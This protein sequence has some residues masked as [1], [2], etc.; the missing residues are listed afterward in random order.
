MIT[1]IS[2]KADTTNIYKNIDG[3]TLS[4]DFK[5]EIPIDIDKQPDWIYDYIRQQTNE[6]GLDTISSGFKQLQIRIW[7]HD[8]LRIDKD[9]IILSRADQKWTGKLITATYSYNDTTQEHFIVRQKSRFIAP[10]SGW[11]NLFY[12]LQNLQILTL[13]D[14]NELPNYPTREDGVDIVVE[15]ATP[16]KY[17]MYHYWS[18]TL[19]SDKFWQAKNMVSISEKLRTEFG[20]Q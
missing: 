19:A 20:M 16:Q 17:R 6:L 3:S 2:C 7:F 15:I 4:E 18:P 12:S 5:R 1:L 14:M 13:G 11:D 8:W 10:K 9:L